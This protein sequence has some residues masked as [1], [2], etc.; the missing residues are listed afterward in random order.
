MSERIDHAPLMRC[1]VCGILF[2]AM[3]GGIYC[4]RCADLI[5][6]EQGIQLIMDRNKGGYGQ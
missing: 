3:Y 2:S 5:A 1:K 6:W 4:G